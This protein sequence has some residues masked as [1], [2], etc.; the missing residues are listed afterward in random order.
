MRSRGRAVAKDYFISGY[1]PPALD[2]SQD[3]KDAT[4]RHEDGFTI[5]EFSKPLISG[6]RKDLHL[7]KGPVFVSFPI[8]G[9]PVYGVVIGMHKRTPVV[10]QNKIDFGLSC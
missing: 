6:D 4:L 3:L 9:G 5:L 2:L 8:G 10:S 7:T 1:R